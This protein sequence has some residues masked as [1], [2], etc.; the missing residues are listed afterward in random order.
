MGRIKKGTPWPGRHSRRP[1]GRPSGR[2][3]GRPSGR[4]SGG[5]SERAARRRGVK[6]KPQSAPPLSRAKSL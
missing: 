6:P 1:S 3:S 4:P 2:L 5:H